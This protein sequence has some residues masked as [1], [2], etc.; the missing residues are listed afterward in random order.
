MN[1]HTIYRSS[2]IKDVI[3]IKVKKYAGYFNPETKSFSVD[4]HLT[5]YSD[6]QQILIQAFSLRNSFQ[7]TYL[8]RDDIGEK[9]FLPMLTDWDLDAAFL[10]SSEPHLKLKLDAEPHQKGLISKITETE[11]DNP[12]EFSDLSE[13]KGFT[14]IFQSKNKRGVWDIQT[15][16]KSWT[17][18]L[19]G[20]FNKLTIWGNQQL[21]QGDTCIFP[22]K[23]P[24]DDEE[25]RS[26]LDQ[27]GRLIRCEELRLRIYH[28]GIDPSLRKV[29]WRI[30]LNVF[31]SD[32]TGEERLSYI[33]QKS[34][35]NF[36]I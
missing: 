32:L 6:L 7:I 36:L 35:P 14:N 16:H 19:G 21:F 9:L 1:N 28:G 10:T 3:K 8:C 20:A 29:V 2:E 17:D 27:E 5:S 31:P 22:H 18:K 26:Y 30:L 13:N 23:P 12:D 4:P 24:L 15:I 11:L 34:G 25:F 33:K